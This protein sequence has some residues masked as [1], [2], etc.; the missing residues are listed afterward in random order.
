MWTGTYRDAL[1]K[2]ADGWWF[3]S[4]H[5]TMDTTENRQAG[6]GSPTAGAFPVQRPAFA[7]SARPPRSVFS[8][9]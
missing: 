1:V 5:L 7:S 3:S 9:P 2:T 8:R 6:T 4:R